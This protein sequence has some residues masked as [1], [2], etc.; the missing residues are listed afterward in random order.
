MTVDTLV[1]STPLASIASDGVLPRC[2]AYTPDHV[3][4]ADG[5]YEIR[6][7]GSR[8]VLSCT[9]VL[10]LALCL[11]MESCVGVRSIYKPA[12]A[13][14]GNADELTDTWRR[15]D[16]AGLAPTLLVHADVAGR[17]MYQAVTILRGVT[18]EATDREAV[19]QAYRSC[20][21]PWTLLTEE[22]ADWTLAATQLFLTECSVVP[23]VPGRRMYHVR[24]ALLRAMGDANHDETLADVLI[25][26]S[27]RAGVQPGVAMREYGRLIS[28]GKISADLSGGLIR[29]DRPLGRSMSADVGVEDAIAIG[30]AWRA[31]FARERGSGSP[32]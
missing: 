3:R 7:L 5:R 27:L 12:H 9:S 4:R 22:W 1:T 28:R 8:T 25:E 29:T 2:L 20:G 13:G 21:L 17:D 11:R 18:A 31:A 26:A 6:G 30:N 24:D 10:E 14:S 32:A 19:R 23:L 16:G 15:V